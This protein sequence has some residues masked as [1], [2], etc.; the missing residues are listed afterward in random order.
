MSGSKEGQTKYAT[1]LPHIKLKVP[2]AALSVSGMKVDRG[3][4]QTVHGIHCLS[5]K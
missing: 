3:M 1:V 4:S 5:D 2:R